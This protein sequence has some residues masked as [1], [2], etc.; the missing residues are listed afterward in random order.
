MRPFSLADW[1]GGKIFF[2]EDYNRGFALVQDDVNIAKND[3][4]NISDRI[5]YEEGPSTSCV[6]YYDQRYTCN[7]ILM[8]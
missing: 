4:N 1:L 5:S 2:S 7:K 8:W 3:I 6:T